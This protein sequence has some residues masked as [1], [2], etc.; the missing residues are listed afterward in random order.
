MAT[1][2]KRGRKRMLNVPREPNGRPSRSG[3]DHKPADVVAIEARMKHWGITKERAR[4]QKAGSYIGYLSILGKRD[5][6]SA[7]QYDAA[8]QYRAL[9]E[10]HQR[11]LKAPGAQYD[12]QIA[13]PS[14]D[15]PSEWYIG[16]CRETVERFRACRDAIQEAQNSN[17]H[18]NLWAALD[19]CII[20][21]ER[22]GH[23]V[24]DLRIACNALARFFR[25]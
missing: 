2:N 13:I 6:L 19:Y 15:E 11:A 17:R 14:G 20:R 3:I 10:S 16:W 5:G 22:H 24:G 12:R 7:D 18:G 4:D 25:V 21:D 1:K 9:Y 23:M 8:V